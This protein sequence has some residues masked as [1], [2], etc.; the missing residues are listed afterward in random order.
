GFTGSGSWALLD[1]AGQTVASLPVVTTTTALAAASSGAVLITGPTAVSV[2]LPAASEGMYRLTFTPSA[3]AFP[4]ASFAFTSRAV[5][6][7]S[8]LG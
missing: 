4:G 7:Y 3:S 8:A 2:H 1:G 6:I 5:V